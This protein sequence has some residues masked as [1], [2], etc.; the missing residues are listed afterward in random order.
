M[1]YFAQEKLYE[2]DMLYDLKLD[3]YLLYSA[4]AKKPIESR[5]SEML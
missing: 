1:V 3:I 4:Y 2:T 5:T